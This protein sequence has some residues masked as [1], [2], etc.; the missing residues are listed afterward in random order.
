MAYYS[1]LFNNINN[2]NNNSVNNNQGINFD[3]F[4]EN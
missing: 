1:V 2:N 3:V 4:D